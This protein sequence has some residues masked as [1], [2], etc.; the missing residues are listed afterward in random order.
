M[1]ELVK[2]DYVKNKQIFNNI[3]NQ[4]SQKLEER[5]EIQH[6]GSTA[7]ENMYGKNIID[8]AIGV[9]DIEQ[10]QRTKKVLEEMNYTAS[11]KSFNG[12]Y[13]FFASTKEESGS[14]DIH[15]HLVIYETA[16]YQEFIILRDYLIE[17]PDEVKAY[18]D[19]KLNIIDLG[20][21]DRREYKRI[22]S[23]YVHDLIERAKIKNI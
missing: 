23:E 7:I 15:I 10:F 3:K 17:N 1:V 20:T 8:I 9:L 14:G 13:Q 4:L 18:S 16:R 21:T 5:I 11:A 19:F 2:Q 12:I 6:V 22:K